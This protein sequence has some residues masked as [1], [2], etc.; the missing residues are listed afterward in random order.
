MELVWRPL[1]TVT[2]RLDLPLLF[3]RVVGDPM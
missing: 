2:A 1:P 3:A